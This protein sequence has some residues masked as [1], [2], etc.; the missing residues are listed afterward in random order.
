VDVEGERRFRELVATRWTP[1]V[2]YAYLLTGD[3]GEAEDVVQTALEK[4]WRRWQTVQADRPEAYLRAVITN[5]VVSR[6]RWRVRRVAETAWDD[7]PYD[8]ADTGAQLDG[9]DARAVRAVIWQELHTLPSR[10]RAVVVLRLWE[11]LPEAEVAQI[12]GCSTGSVKSQLSRALERLRSREE[13]RALVG[14]PPSPGVA[15]VPHPGDTPAP[16]S[17]GDAR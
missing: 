4:A 15:A 5:V 17:G 12:L 2:R 9:A 6:Y 16:L 14:E 1:L 3:A 11:D 13:L 10:M 7:V 8:R